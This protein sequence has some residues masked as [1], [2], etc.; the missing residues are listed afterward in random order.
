[1]S[2]DMGFGIVFMAAGAAFFLDA[3]GVLDL[4]A[5]YVW[6]VL[7]IGIGLALIIGGRKRAEPPAEEPSDETGPSEAAVQAEGE[8]TDT[9]TDTD[10]DID[11]DTQP[12]ASDTGDPRR[13]DG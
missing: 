13:D 9:D 8:H 7:L 3:V 2:R 4:A 10:T 6:P 5:A 11:T 12:D 1:M